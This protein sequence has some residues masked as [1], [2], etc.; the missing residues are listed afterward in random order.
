M[1]LKNFF[2]F[3]LENDIV[4]NLKQK[5]WLLSNAYEILKNKVNL[6]ARLPIPLNG[7]IKNIVIK[8]YGWRN[9]LSKIL[10]P[11]TRSRA[12]KAYDASVKLLKNGV[13]V[14]FPLS[15]YTFRKLGQVKENFLITEDVPKNKMS[16]E[17][18]QSDEYSQDIKHTIVK[19]I[20]EMVAK[21]HKSNFIHRDL[22]R[23]NFLVQN[24]HDP[25]NLKITLIDL[26][27]VR[28]LPV[29]T[30][31]ARIQDISKLNLCKCNQ[32]YMHEDCLWD[33]FF[34]NYINWNII[35]ERKLIKI[36]LAKNRVVSNFKKKINKF[37]RKNNNIPQK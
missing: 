27:R 7:Q 34:K 36:I 19:K 32:E 9:K 35:H 15:V 22:T 2:G 8:N 20:A 18:F 1:I 23:G 16:R 3:S 14:P 25:A 26:N 33:T 31:L 13:S 37:S 11:W 12:E 21:L 30:M 4:E 5:D 28:E 17:I 6:V 10:S 29:M 24:Y